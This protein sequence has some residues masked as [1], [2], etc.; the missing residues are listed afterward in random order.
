MD[1]SINANAN[2]AILGTMDDTG[3]AA[4]E[5]TKATA[6]RDD[7]L[8]IKSAEPSA[9]GEI[10][11]IDFP[12]EDVARSD[13]LGQLV[14]ERG[15]LPAAAP[16]AEL[17]VAHIKILLFAANSTFSPLILSEEGDRPQ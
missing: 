14:N 3:V 15:V 2:K 17:P 10:S 5:H 7:N 16:A 8:T 4:A 6:R 11:A 9:P 13:K 12:S 1:I